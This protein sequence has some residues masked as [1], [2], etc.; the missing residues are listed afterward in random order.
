ML[1]GL[2]LVGGSESESDSDSSSSE[3]DSGVFFVAGGGGF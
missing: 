1:R 3:S 2:V